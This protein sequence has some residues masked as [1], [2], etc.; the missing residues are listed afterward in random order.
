MNSIPKYVLTVEEK[1]SKEPSLIRPDKYYRYD[2]TF[3]CWNMDLIEMLILLRIMKI[4]WK[5]KDKY[6]VLKINWKTK[7]KYKVLT[8]NRKT[9]E[10][11]Y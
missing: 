7:D 11:V 10:I 9:K 6:K 8:S 2:E 1:K 4:N 5:T 3:L